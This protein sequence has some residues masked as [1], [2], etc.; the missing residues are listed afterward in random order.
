MK[1]DLGKDI[2]ERKKN[3]VIEEDQKEVNHFKCESCSSEFVSETALMKH[4]N[5]KH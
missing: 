5:T 3:V 4:N 2:T 1:F